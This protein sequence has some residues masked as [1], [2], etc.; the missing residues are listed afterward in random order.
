M[1]PQPI[2]AHKA[3]INHRERKKVNSRITQILFVASLGALAMTANAQYGAPPSQPAD[4]SMTAAP[5]TAGADRKLSESDIRLYREGR[6]ACNKITG[7]AQEDCRKQ[8]A[9]KYV[10]KQ[11][12]NL[13]G[14]KLDECLKGEYPGE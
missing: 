14:Q 1:I 9:S 7:A 13:S 6:R 2:P 3:A 10:D 5:A 4:K 8:L 12:R 11:C